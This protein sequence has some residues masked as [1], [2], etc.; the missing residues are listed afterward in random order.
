MKVDRP[1]FDL[2]YML[3]STTYGTLSLALCKNGHVFRTQEGVRQCSVLS[4]LRVDIQ[5]DTAAR[6]W[7]F[8]CEH[9][10][11][12]DW[13]PRLRNEILIADLASRDFNEKPDPRCSGSGQHERCSSVT[14]SARHKQYLLE[15]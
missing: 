14:T 10:T 8:W 11:Y 9:E 7:P 15:E 12:T 5:M 1:L 4:W 2:V 13:H 6:V 3:Q